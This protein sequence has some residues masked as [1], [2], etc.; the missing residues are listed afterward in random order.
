MAPLERPRRPRRGRTHPAWRPRP[1][2]EQL[3]ARDQS[4][5]SVARSHRGVGA[6]RRTAFPH[7]VRTDLRP[8]RRRRAPR[9][10]SSGRAWGP[11]RRRGRGP[12]GQVRRDAGAAARGRGSRDLRPDQSRPDAR[13]RQRARAAVRRAGDRRLRTGARRRRVGTR[14]RARSRHRHPRAPGAATD[15]DARPTTRA[16]ADRRRRDHIFGGA[17]GGRGQL[18]ERL[19]GGLAPQLAATSPAICT[20]AARPARRSSPRAHTQTRSPTPG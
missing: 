14:P 13:A 10:R 7:A 3:R 5:E 12:V 8:A 9:C 16:R 4:R 11:A 6:P 1:T 15:V 18:L 20:P 2:R 19:V 17:D